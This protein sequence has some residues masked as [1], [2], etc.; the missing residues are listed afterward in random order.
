MRRAARW[1]RRHRVTVGVAVVV[2]GLVSSTALIASGLAGGRAARAAYPVGN[3]YTGVEAGLFSP[4]TPPPGA[5]N[6][7]CKP[8]PQH[9]YPVI[10]VHGTL[11][12]EAFNWQAL[13]PALA[14]A[15]Y[16]V[17]TFNYGQTYASLGIFDGLGDIPA[18]AGQLATFVNSVLQATG[19]S[20]VDIVGHSQGGMM[21]R[22]YVK[23]LGGASKVRQLVGLAPSNHGTTLDGLVNLGSMLGLLGFVNTF[24]YYLGAPALAEQEVGS[25]FLATLNSGGDTVPGPRYTVIETSHDEVVTPYTSAFLSG[26]NVSNVL[27]QNQCPSDAVG[28][29]GIAYDNVAIQDVLNALGTDSPYFIPSP[30]SCNGYGPGL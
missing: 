13:A 20:R 18:S 14:N 25:S 24:V 3:I 30:V 19:A 6:W 21:P 1:V 28:H 26:P 16:C 12:N 22:Y 27:I 5:N 8:T 7:G 10:L 9:P 11:E 15:G 4:N 23:F 17:F 2:V 29:V